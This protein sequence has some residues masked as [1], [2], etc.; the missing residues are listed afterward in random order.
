MNYLAVIREKIK[1][2]DN[3]KIEISLPISFNQ[4]EKIEKLTK[5]EKREI[6]AN[7]LSKFSNTDLINLT[8]KILYNAPHRFWYYPNQ[9]EYGETKKE[10]TGLAGLLIHTK[11][12]FKFSEVLCDSWGV[13]DTE[14]DIIY[15]ATL[16]HDI[17]LDSFGIIDNKDNKIHYHL[18]EPRLKFYNYR[19]GMEK[20]GYSIK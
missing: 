10:E 19:F 8:C 15:C 20:N 3:K 6:F 17:F 13:E 18:I 14:R 2:Y 7:E 16:I 4:I 11:R 5:T 12:A 1:T 9:S